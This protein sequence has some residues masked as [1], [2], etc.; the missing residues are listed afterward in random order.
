[1]G[2]QLWSLKSNLQKHTHSRHCD[3][4][5]R[6][7]GSKDLLPG[8]PKAPKLQGD[9][10]QEGQGVSILPGSTTIEPKAERLWWSDQAHLP[11]EGQ[12]HQEDCAQDGNQLRQGQEEVRHHEANQ[13]MQV[14]RARW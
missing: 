1:M 3:H 9:P 7:K 13:A 11:Q 14:L 4:G 10:V 6:S 12:D 2:T 8:H 5:K